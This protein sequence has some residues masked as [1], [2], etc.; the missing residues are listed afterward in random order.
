MTPADTLKVAMWDDRELSLDIT[1]ASK[2]MASI[3]LSVEDQRRLFIWLG[4]ELHK[5]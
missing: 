1:V 2:G 3:V 5:Y 4:A